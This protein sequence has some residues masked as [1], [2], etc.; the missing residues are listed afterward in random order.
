MKKN[1]LTL[2]HKLILKSLFHSILQFSFIF[3][4]AWYQDCLF[5]MSIIYCCFFIF[6]TQFEKQYHASTTWL[7]TG[8]TFV[9]FFI[10]SNITPRKELTLLLIVVFTYTINLIS[11]YIRDYFDLRDRF[12]AKKVNITKGMSRDKLLSICNE[13]NLNELETN[14]LLYYYCDRL[15]LTAIS[16]KIGYSYDYT[17]ELKSKI[18]RTIKAKNTD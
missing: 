4:F 3:A 1:K 13:N 18:I 9:V 6:R 5:E 2:H 7:C 16:F 8:Y 15:T 17:A 12:K 14:I 11:F 10:V